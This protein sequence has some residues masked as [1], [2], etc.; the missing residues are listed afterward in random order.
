MS[1]DTVNTP[2]D[3][4]GRVV[5]YPAG[6][7][8]AQPALRNERPDL[9]PRVAAG[10]SASSLPGLVSALL[11]M[12]GQAHHLANGL[13]IDAARGLRR[14]LAPRERTLLHIE[15]VREHLRRIWLDWPRLW[16]GPADASLAQLQELHGCPAL[17]GSLNDMLQ[18]VGLQPAD[19]TFWDTTRGW[20]EA[21]V[22]DMP[23]ALWLGRWQAEGEAW[24][25]TW[26]K[27]AQTWPAQWLHAI[28][29]DAQ[30][31]QAP[32][33]TWW[34]VPDAWPA[35]SA[36]LQAQPGLGR[37]PSWPQAA[38]ETGPW[39]RLHQREALAARTGAPQSAWWRLGGRLADLA[40]LACPAHAPHAHNDLGPCGPD[41]LQSGQWCG[42][43]H[44]GI[45]WVEMA[46]GALLHWVQL[47]SAH[48]QAR[49]LA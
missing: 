11:S 9:V 48:P 41:T 15:T 33:Q 8:R 13:A 45:A 31:L 42:P 28:Q 44:T 47:D 2:G 3:L 27:Q 38:A 34:S 19:D 18:P 14:D 12:C 16:P 25:A 22:F 37:Q 35:L 36:Q 39:C 30:A 32:F 20:L 29:A 49:V 7:G 5:W 17:Q 40:R 24:L 26:A 1:L 4:A 46:R 6:P 21:H 23:V 10:R 43:A